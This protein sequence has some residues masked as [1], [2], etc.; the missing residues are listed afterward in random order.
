MGTVKCLPSLDRT[1]KDMHSCQ[2]RRALIVRGRRAAQK[3]GRC[4]RSKPLEARLPTHSCSYS[5]TAGCSTLLSRVLQATTFVI[6]AET[7]PRD[8]NASCSADLPCRKTGLRRLRWRCSRTSRAQLEPGD[9]SSL[10]I[11]HVGLPRLP[12]SLERRL[13]GTAQPVVPRHLADGRGKQ[14]HPA[15]HQRHSRRTRQRC[16]GQRDSQDGDG[17][18]PEVSYEHDRTA[19]HALRSGARRH[20]HAFADYPHGT[21]RHALP[22]RGTFI[23]LHASHRPKTP[24]RWVLSFSVRH[25]HSYV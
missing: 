11:R 20:E 1:T 24:T 22:V 2:N 13:S 17:R 15:Q 5:L 21:R 23:L 4:P 19:P 14:R 12:S 6:F 7:S 18:L 25:A 8:R 3:R 9:A 10:G 16:V